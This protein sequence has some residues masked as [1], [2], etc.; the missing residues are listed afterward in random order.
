M[1]GRDIIQD[2]SADADLD[3][4]QT[5]VMRF[6]AIIAF[7]LLVIFIPLVRAIPEKD[8]TN[9]LEVLK[10]NQHLMSEIQK[11]K[12]RT[13][14]QAKQIDTLMKNSSALEK[15]KEKELSVVLV[16][17]KGESR[18]RKIKI[19][20]LQDFLKKER[21]QNKEARQ[22]LNNYEKNFY[23][24]QV[25]LVQLQ[26]RY[27][28]ALKSKAKKQ[29]APALIKT[30]KVPKVLQENQK[31]GVVKQPLSSKPPREGKSRVIFSSEG[32]LL[33]L[34][35][36]GG[37]NFYLFSSGKL[38]ESYVDGGRVFYRQLSKSPLTQY[39]M[40]CALVP[41]SIQSAIKQQLS[42]I[43]GSSK[44]CF[45]TLSTGINDNLKV[46]ISKYKSGTFVIGQNGSVTYVSN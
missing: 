25:K 6:M 4:L 7:S 37:V 27:K 41:A 33:H 13:A 14:N 35:E 40:S 28:I 30:E 21:I 9:N 32:S 24:V 8:T 2:Q 42:N 26:S 12:E 3:A 18:K 38:F 5:D 31:K 1:I 36:N 43:L 15:K 17:I 34:I 16:Q 46:S 22:K 11:L 29:R 19:N 23:E 20:Q 45:L 39:E 10:K 44:R